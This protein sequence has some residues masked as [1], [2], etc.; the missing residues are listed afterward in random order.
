[1]RGPNAVNLD[2]GI[3]RNFQMGERFTLQFRGEALNMTNTTHFNNP[4][5]NVSNLQLNPDGTIRNL[6][7]FTTISSTTGTGREGIDERVF[8]FGMRLRF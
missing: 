3:V 4:A 1:V 7:G 2:F 8:R 6:G 5:S